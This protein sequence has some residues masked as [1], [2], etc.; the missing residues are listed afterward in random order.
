M[1][2]T[3]INLHVKSWA[4][5]SGQDTIAG[6]AQPSDQ[7]IPTALKR[8]ITPIGQK[9]M[10]LAWRVGSCCRGKPRIILTSRHSE[11]TRTLGLINMLEEEGE[12]SPADFSLAV[13]HGLAGLFSI[14]TKNH[15]AHTALSAGVESLAYGLI[16]AASCLADGDEEVLLL[17]FDEILPDTFGELIDQP[18]TPVALAL[19]L[20]REGQQVSQITMSMTPQ[21]GPADCNLA[22][23][24][25]NFINS[26]QL[27]A[28]TRS[29]RTIWKW[30]KYPA[31]A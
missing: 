23:Q 12:I 9:L 15:S 5:W 16:E 27:A 13:H 19:L 6:P 14:A 24:F 25:I 2:P 20:T 26:D 3:T 22:H 17:H 30:E 11:F 10:E 28:Q 1:S 4:S 18:E 29:E 7:P 31:I 21:Q 8:R